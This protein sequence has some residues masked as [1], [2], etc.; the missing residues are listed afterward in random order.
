MSTFEEVKAGPS[1]RGRE[2]RHKVNV[3]GLTV[4]DIVCHVL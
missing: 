4:E 3:K 2:E 1:N